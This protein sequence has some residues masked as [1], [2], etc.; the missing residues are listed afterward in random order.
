MKRKFVIYVLDPWS[1]RELQRQPAS[2]SSAGEEFPFSARNMGWV[3][4]KKEVQEDE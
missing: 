3:H 4:S 2:M 1:L